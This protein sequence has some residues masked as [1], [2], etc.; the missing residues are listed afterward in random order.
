MSSGHLM[1]HLGMNPIPKNL[2]NIETSRNNTRREVLPPQA[3]GAMKYLSGDVQVPCQR[4]EIISGGHIRHPGG[5]HDKEGVVH[6]RGGGFVPIAMC[7]I[8]LSCS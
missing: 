8:S 7:L 1:G 4:G 3:C 2:I 6:P 5:G